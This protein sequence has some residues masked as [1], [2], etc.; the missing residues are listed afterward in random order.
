M[1][2]LR[3]ILRNHHYANRTEQTHCQ[4]ILRYIQHFG[5]KPLRVF[6]RGI[7]WGIGGNRGTLPVLY[8][9]LLFGATSL[10]W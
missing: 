7:G 3:R 8:F 6:S 4:W 5:G 9:F 1:D 10:A 2:Q